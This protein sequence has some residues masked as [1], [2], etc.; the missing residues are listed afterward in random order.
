MDS[1][2]GKARWLAKGNPGEMPDSNYCKGTTTMCLFMHT[3]YFPQKHLFHSFLSLCGNS[4]YKVSG[5]GV[6]SLAAGLVARIQHSHCHNL[7]SISGQERKSCFKP[8]QAEAAWDQYHRTCFLSLCTWDPSKKTAFYK[9]EG[10]PQGGTK[11]ASTL[12]SDFPTYRTV[13]NKFLLF[14]SMVGWANI[15]FDTKKGGTTITNI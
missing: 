14:K 2:Q 1:E 5:P 7:T 12:I 10:S 13:R 15:N 4:V 9:P 8:L 11:W 3:L 6:L